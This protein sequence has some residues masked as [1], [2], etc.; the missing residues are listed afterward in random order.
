MSRNDN[1]TYLEFLHR[2]NQLMREYEV[3]LSQLEEADSENYWPPAII[4]HRGMVYIERRCEL[5]PGGEVLHLLNVPG[6]RDIG[7]RELRDFTREAKSLMVID[8][9]IF[10]VEKE[11]VEC[12]VRELME[13]ARVGGQWLKRIHFVHDHRHTRSGIKRCLKQR[14]KDEGVYMTDKHTTEI[15]DRVWIADRQRALVIGT[16]LNGIGKRAAFLLLLPEYDLKAL[17]DFLDERDLSR[18]S[19]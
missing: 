11:Q 13:S 8:P 2:Y 14:L 17:L 6:Q 4:P 9:Y 19:S 3:F 12:F 16:S 5:A 7:L 15:H 10:A 18:A 1:Q